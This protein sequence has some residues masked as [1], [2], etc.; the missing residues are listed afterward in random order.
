MYLERI[1]IHVKAKT[2]K[3]TVLVKNENN[4]TLMSE[5]IENANFIDSRT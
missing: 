3:K 5:Q 2:F 4:T 1:I